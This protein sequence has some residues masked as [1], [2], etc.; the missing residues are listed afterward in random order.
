MAVIDTMIRQLAVK[1]KELMTSLGLIKNYV[2]EEGY[3]RNE[4]QVKIYYRK[5][6]N[7]MCEAWAECSMPSLKAYSTNVLGNLSAYTDYFSMPALFTDVPKKMLSA[8]YG[9]GI[10]IVSSGGLNDSKDKIYIHFLAG[11][12][13]GSKLYWRAYLWGT[14]K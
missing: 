10:T 3:L 1:V 6:Q 14:Y 8:Q 9:S 4:A 12:K 2:T 11:D 5:W 7:G 13:D